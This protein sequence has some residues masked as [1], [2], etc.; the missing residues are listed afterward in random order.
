V[1]SKYDYEVKKMTKQKLHPN[2]QKFKNFV[3]QHPGLVVKVKKGKKTWQDLYEDWYLLGDNDP[4]WESFRR[5]EKTI[6]QKT[7]TK[8]ESKSDLSTTE[9]INQVI[10]RVKQ[11]DINQVQQYIGSLSE[12]LDTLQKLLG[13]MQ[14]P[15]K[16]NNDEL[17]PSNKRKNK[18]FFS[19]R[20]D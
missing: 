20:K 19:F 11:L 8:Q 17:T 1:Y 18:N 4:K 5:D 9:L 16:G 2:V 12:G 10:A 7:E 3:K 15:E 6:S 13:E 14:N